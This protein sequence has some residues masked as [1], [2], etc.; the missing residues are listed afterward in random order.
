MKLKWSKG[1]EWRYHR[2][3]RRVHCIDDYKS[4]PPWDKIDNVYMKQHYNISKEIQYS[5]DYI[6]DVL[7]PAGV[8]SNSTSLPL[9]HFSHSRYRNLKTGDKLA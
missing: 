2:Y 9:I 8:D 6:E 3:F 1:Q 4:N 5:V 7:L